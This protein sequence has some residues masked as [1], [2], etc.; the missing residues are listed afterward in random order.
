MKLYAI[1][2]SLVVSSAIVFATDC[3]PTGKQMEAAAPAP[4]LLY[5]NRFKNRA[6]FEKEAMANPN[7]P[8]APIKPERKYMLCSGWRTLV[9][10]Y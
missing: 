5:N 2:P 3:A 10:R 1:K 6:R 8:L 7:N 9:L 4:M